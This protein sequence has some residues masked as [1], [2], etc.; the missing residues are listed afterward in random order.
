MRLKQEESWEEEASHGAGK[1]ED[2]DR[3]L[4]NWSRSSFGSG[5]DRESE[6]NEQGTS[7]DET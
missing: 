3:E 7:D 2:G 4:Y 5:G 6:K 1:H